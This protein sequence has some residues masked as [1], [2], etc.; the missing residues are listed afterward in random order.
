MKLEMCRFFLY[1]I[2]NDALIEISNSKKKIQKVSD[3][4][5]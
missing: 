5:N 4:G 2:L 3:P 1:I